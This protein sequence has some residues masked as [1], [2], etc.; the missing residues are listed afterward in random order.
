MADLRAAHPGGILL[1]LGD[2]I[3]LEP[4]AGGGKLVLLGLAGGVAS[5][6]VIDTLVRGSRRARWWPLVPAAILGAV[7]AGLAAERVPE[8]ADLLR[9]WPL[10]L[11]ALGAWLLFVRTRRAGGG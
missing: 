11:V 7:G 5:I 1:G 2:G 8:V 9:L 10:L 4:R 6:Y 3:A